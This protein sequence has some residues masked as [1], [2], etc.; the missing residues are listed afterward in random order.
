[1]AH[2]LCFAES[3]TKKE[4]SVVSSLNN[5][6]EVCKIIGSKVK[7]QHWIDCCREAGKCCDS[8]VEEQ[9]Q[10]S[11]T[12]SYGRESSATVDISTA[13]CPAT[14]DMFKCWFKGQPATKPRLPCPDF[15]VESVMACVDTGKVWRDVVLLN[16][17]IVLYY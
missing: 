4:F 8:M 7:C 17:I 1:M 9:W 5:S 13:A 15:L 10:Q 2:N 14:F 3:L 12:V 6:K 16:Y 11:S